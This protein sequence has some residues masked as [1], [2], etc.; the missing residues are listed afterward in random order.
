MTQKQIFWII[1]GVI[2]TVGGIAIAIPGSLIMMAAGA[3][4]LGAGGAFIYVLWLI[5]GSF[6][7]K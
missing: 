5:A 4:I 7:S 3:Y 6:A 2:L 1:I